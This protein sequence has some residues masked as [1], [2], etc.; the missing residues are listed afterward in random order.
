MDLGFVD[1]IVDWI[2]DIFSDD[3]KTE[4][5]SVQKVAVPGR[6]YDHRLNKPPDLFSIPKDLTQF[7]V[8]WLV[9][10][11]MSL[12]GAAAM[13]GNLWRE[14]YLNPSQKQLDSSGAPKGPGSGVAQWTDSTLTR[15]QSDNG[16]GRWDTYETE[17]FPKLKGYGDYWKDHGLEDLEPQLAFIIYELKE[18]FPG[19]WNALRSKGSI[20][21]KTIMVLKKYEVARDRD[22]PEEQNLRVNFAEKIYN[23]AKQDKSLLK[24]IA[25]KN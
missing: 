22:D 3:K 23:I 4:V 14:S 20:R 2:K 7:T 21:D 18:F 10:A 1:D 24:M 12:E 17:F 15:N 25:Q 8:K 13:T 6:P 11:G 9:G 5:K 16:T 19:V